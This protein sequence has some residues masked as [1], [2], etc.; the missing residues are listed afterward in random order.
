MRLFFLVPSPPKRRRSE[1]SSLTGNVRR[2][3][4]G[5]GARVGKA[6]LCGT[7][8]PRRGSAWKT[9]RYPS[10]SMGR[11]QCLIGQLTDEQ[12][13]EK[14]LAAVMLQLDLIGPRD[15]RSPRLVPVV[16]QL[17][18]IDNPFAVQPDRNLLA[19]HPDQEGVPLARPF[20]GQGQRH[21]SPPTI[22]P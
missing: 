16:L 19:D 17:D 10:S 9:P 7:V 3:F 12:V 22:I 18:P 4:G 5:E 14:E 11:H 20:V 1:C 8:S 15:R 13:F 6:D 21:I 2:L